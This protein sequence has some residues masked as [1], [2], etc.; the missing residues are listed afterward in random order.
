MGQPGLG[1]SDAGHA[2]WGRPP[3]L[4]T[5][6][7]PD[8]LRR[9]ELVVTRRLDGLLQGDYRGL[10]PGHGSEL[11]ETRPYQPGDDVRR[12]DWN[13]TA[14]TLEPHVRES[15]ADREL[16]TWVA[17]DTSASLAF[18]TADCEKRDLALAATAAVGFLTQRAGNRVGAVLIGDGQTEII[19]ARSGRAHLQAVLRRCLAVLTDE[20]GSAQLAA[21]LQRLAG[22]ARRRGLVVVV[23]DFLDPGDWERPLR[24]LATRH[25]VLA[26]EL[27]DP[28]EL[29][30]PD[31]GV[32]DLVDPETGAQAEVNTSDA[33]VRRA[34][35]TAAAEQRGRIAASL[36]RTGVDHL[37]LRTDEDW[38]LALVRF[39]TWRRDRV[40]ALARASVP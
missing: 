9:L 6:A 35:A 36:R 24:A 18:G 1:V 10:V 28:R 29:E 31:V 32:L 27:V 13:V 20:P 16:E 4:V 40:D 21:G 38:L 30:L 26:V 39:V 25:E 37:V 7:A 22:V 11:G 33:S 12:I 15:I 2:G 23:S 3:S 8:V 19:P 17:V 14:R 5:S 34:F